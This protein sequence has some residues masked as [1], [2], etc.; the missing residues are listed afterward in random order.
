MG[1]T[2]KG[3]R[4]HHQQPTPPAP[5]TEPGK[6]YLRR[7]RDLQQHG[8]GLSS[9]AAPGILP[10]PSPAHF[11]SAPSCAEYIAGGRPFASPATQTGGLAWSLLSAGKWSA[12]ANLGTV[13]FSAPNCTTD[14]D[15]G[16]ICAFYTVGGQ[17]M[18]KSIRRGK[19]GRDFLNLGG[20]GRR[21]PKLHLLEAQRTG[22]LLCQSHRP[23]QTSN[24]TTF[25]GAAWSKADW[26]SYSNLEGLL[27]LKTPVAP[28]RPPENWSAPFSVPDTNN[29]LFSNVL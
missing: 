17:T 11:Y 20:P 29:A 2:W 3:S 25:S 18:V 23:V 16:V 4:R 15:S 6:V 9:P 8:S 22:S 14:H 13:A 21:N 24:V 5:A 26:T 1:E 28:P 27:Q 10:S 7:Y 19:P 12:F